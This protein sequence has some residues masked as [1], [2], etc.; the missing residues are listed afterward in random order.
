MPLSSPRLSYPHFPKEST[1]SPLLPRLPANLL[2]SFDK[3]TRMHRQPQSLGCQQ[4][5]CLYNFLADAF[6]RH[7]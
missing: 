5:E 4:D 6:S 2:Q 7:I 1:L 3:S